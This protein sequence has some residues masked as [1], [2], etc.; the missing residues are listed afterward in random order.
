[1]G[2]L[3]G[4]ER[5]TVETEER[6]GRTEDWRK[7]EARRRRGEFHET[8]ASAILNSEMVLVGAGEL[9]DHGVRV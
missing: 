5:R 2:K 6:K 9:C 3:L 4:V 7:G 1:M 8:L